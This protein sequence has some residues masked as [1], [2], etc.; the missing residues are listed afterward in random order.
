MSIN[1]VGQGDFM[2][3]GLFVTAK[4][5]SEILGISVPLGYKIIAKLN[6]ELKEKGYITF[7]GRL[8]RRY[9]EEKCIYQGERITTI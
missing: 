5:V 6:G 3:K 1:F 9:F 4:E 8:N 2:E 7:S